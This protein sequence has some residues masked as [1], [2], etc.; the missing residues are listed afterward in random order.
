MSAIKP[1]NVPSRMH[2]TALPPQL[3]LAPAHHANSALCP[4]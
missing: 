1:S 4:T 3:L 2:G